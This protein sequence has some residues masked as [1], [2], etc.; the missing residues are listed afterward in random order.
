MSDERAAPLGTGDRRQGKLAWMALFYLGL[1]VFIVVESYLLLIPHFPPN[2][3]EIYSADRLMP[4]FPPLVLGAAVLALVSWFS[5]RLSSLPLALV[6]LLV[7]AIVARLSY[8]YF[9]IGFADMTVDPDVKLFFS[10]AQQ[11]AQGTYPK[12]EYPQLALLYFWG[13]Y[14]LA[15]GAL[16]SFRIALPL[17]NLVCDLVV[18]ACIWGVGLRCQSRQ[19][20]W[21]LALFVAV[22][23]FSLILWFSKFDA[24]P[25]AF[26]ALSAYLFI[27]RREW[28]L[29]LALAAGFYAKWF[30]ALAVPIMWLYLLRRQE[31]G[32]LVKLSVALAA[33]MIAI[34][35]PFWLADAERFL[36]TYHFHADRGAMAESI[37]YLPT[38][39]L[40][41]LH[42]LAPNAAPWDG[43]SS[44][45]FTNSTTSLI[46]FATIGVIALA[47]LVAP[48]PRPRGL[49]L[50]ALAVLAFIVLNRVFSPQ[51]AVVMLAAYALAL[52]TRPLPRA[53]LTALVLA[54]LV[55]TAAN[56]FVWPLL[57]SFWVTS[58]TVLFALSLALCGVV[59]GT[60]FLPS[61][62]S[63]PTAEVAH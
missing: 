44:D 53:A 6:G 41:P 43:F 59:V 31:W 19:S 50:A 2:N 5:R 35:L 45:I 23:P 55:L 62:T 51:Y 29:G 27:A 8:L 22:S 40:E 52:C 37:F 38:Y 36:F 49:K 4:F 39:W 15:G 32:A 56:M 11:L 47:A 46:Q 30:P 14:S 60:L 33:G 57:A 48:G 10:Y 13:A 61:H 12:M 26:F 63:E 17:L 18:I 34:G 42:R 24:L 3:A 20:A 54:C 16:D 9:R 21:L 7:V 1:A 58:S 25:A 28:L